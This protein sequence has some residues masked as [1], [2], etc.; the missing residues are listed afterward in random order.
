MKNFSSILLAVAVLRTARGEESKDPNLNAESA[1]CLADFNAAREKAGLEPFAAET[2]DTNKMP[3]TNSA[4]IK[5]IC[6]TIKGTNVSKQAADYVRTGTYAYA[7]QIGPADGCSAAVSYWKKAYVNFGELPPEYTEDDTGVYAESR[8]RSLV[9][10]YNPK[11]GATVDCAYI[12]CPASTATSTSTPSTT[13]PSTT[14]PSTTKPNPE[15]TTPEQTG[16]ITPQPESAAY[17]HPA[18]VGGRDSE[19]PAKAFTPPVSDE[20]EIK[21][22]KEDGQPVRRL[23]AT[24]ET[25]TSLVCLTNPAALTQKQSTGRTKSSPMGVKECRDIVVTVKAAIISQISLEYF[26]LTAEFSPNTMRNFSSILL[27]VAVL[28]TARGEDSKDPNLNAESANCLADFNA[29]REKAGL[30]PFAAET[31]YQFCGTTVSKEAAE[32]AR[33]GTYAYAPQIGP[34]DGCSAAVSYW[35][36]AYVNFGEFPPEY[37][38]ND[39]GV[40][41]DSRNRSLVALYNPKDGATVD[42]AYITCPAST[43]TSTTTPSTT[44]PTTTKP[45]SEETTPEQ[46]EPAT[47]QPPQAAAYLHSVSLEGRY[48]ESPAKAFTPPVSDDE[49]TKDQNEGGQPVRRLSAASETVTSLVCLTN[50][51]ALVNQEKPFSEEVWENIKEAIEN[52]AS[53]SRQSALIATALLLLTYFTIL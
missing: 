36:K 3:I 38:D 16:P 42:C 7:P 12:T 35:K 18:S 20:E 10:L 19:S 28:R 8:N 41:A 14:T 34:A 17:L 22:A 23:S 33:T 30:E 52:S 9:A 37:A 4:Y 49:E 29:A 11:G 26:T 47:P 46:N 25:V 27:A 5:A 53:D 50:P 15:E 32:Y 44:I 6:D 48:S 1:D 51:A 43:A 39:T 31:T 13:T 21:V 24:S 2:T 40:Y 45:S